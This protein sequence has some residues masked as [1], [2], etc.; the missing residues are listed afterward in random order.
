ME[1]PLKRV[2]VGKDPS[3]I[4]HNLGFCIRSKSLALHL[5]HLVHRRHHALVE[6]AHDPHRA[7][8]NERDDQ[9]A[10]GQR[11]HVVSIVRRGGKM[12]EENQMHADLRNRKHR[13]RNRNGRRPDNSPRSVGYSGRP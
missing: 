6:M 13:Q 5:H 1:A 8:N 9:D 11:Q 4:R 2:S 3:L 7:S 12:E 10:E